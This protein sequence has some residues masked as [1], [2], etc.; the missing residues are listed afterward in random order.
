MGEGGIKHGVMSDR[1][2]AS[3]VASG[4]KDGSVSSTPP[5]DGWLLGL[6]TDE[7]AVETL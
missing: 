4:E 2:I 3:C 6:L 1:Q 5:P 7:S